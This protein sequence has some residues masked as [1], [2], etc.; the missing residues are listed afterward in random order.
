LALVLA[1]AT[2][3]MAHGANETSLLLEVER[4]RSET[5]EQRARIAELELR[6]ARAEAE[7]RS[8]TARQEQ[9]LNAKLD[10]LI[11]L[12]Q[13]FVQRA[14]AASTAQGVE[15]GHDDERCPPTA[16]ADLADSFD[17]QL[18]LWRE[19][20]RNDPPPWQGGLSREKREALRVLLKRDRTL[21]LV[22]PLA[23]P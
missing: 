9:R 8:Q 4:A 15:A 11:A 2:G 12:Q 1:L 14:G 7:Q 19:R 5:L 13:Q 22:N 21:D 3:C 10:Q 16:N 20:L 17:E 23:D 6:L 18:E